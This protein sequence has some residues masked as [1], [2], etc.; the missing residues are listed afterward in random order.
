[1]ISFTNLILVFLFGSLISY[2]LT[3]ANKVLG[4]IF[5][6]LLSAYALYYVWNI[7]IGHTEKLF[8]ILGVDNQI[9]VT[10]LGKFFAIV[11]FIVFTS[12]AFFAIDW[13]RFK[14]KNPAAFNT[15]YLLTSVGSLGVFF[16]NDL[17]TLY[18]FWEIAVLGS[19]LI[20][21]MGNKQSKEAAVTYVIMS[22]IGS[23]M[24]LFATFSIF[25]RY[26]VVSFKEVII[27]LLNEPSTLYKWFVVLF[28]AA[29]GIAKSGI[30][31]LHTWL[32]K[33]HGNA[34]DAFSA[35]FSGQL[36]KLGSY[37]LAI[38]L[39]VFPSIKM[40]MPFYQGIPIL[41]YLLIWLGNISIIVGTFMAIRQND[42]KY[43][44]AY[45][46]VANGGYILV[47]LATLDSIGFAGGLFHVFN[48]AIISVMVFLSFAVVIHRTGTTK[49]DEMGGLIWRMPWTFVTYLVGIIALAGIPPTS[50]FI[51]KWMIFNTLV[52]H[53]MFVTAAIAFI[54]SVGS[55][56]YVFRP[57]AGVFLGQLKKKHYDLKEGSI[58]ML[59]PMLLMVVLTILMGIYPKPIL[60]LIISVENELGIKPLQYVGTIIKTPLGQ[61]NTLTVFVMFAVGFI[62]A[63]II[64]LLSPKAKKVELTNQYTGG[65]FLYNYDLYHYATGFYRFI[66]RLYDKHPSFEK[67]YEMIGVFFKSIGDFVTGLIYKPSPSGYI[68]WISIVIL[69][70]YWVRW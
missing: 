17:I 33:V 1:M 56:L 19:F 52:R 57:L 31:P 8:S 5:N 43:L 40:F 42:M 59:I 67:L 26:G 66:E 23:Y 18:I 53:G 7:E 28:I 69:I 34:P 51:S 47:G 22:A 2:L 55:F 16:A 24:Y 38:S 41:N 68:F 50:G 44:I 20:V 25:N 6:F 12:V 48:H 46:S 65:E 58:I 60:D 27:N 30:F 15:F 45:S 64:Y 10:S 37:V 35:V 13:I 21:P 36:V 49:I 61:W 63:F 29:A 4:S 62:I 39:A 3:K 54:G 32:K 11:S 9:V 70:L 14:P